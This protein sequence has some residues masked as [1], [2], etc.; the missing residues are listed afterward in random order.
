M[1]HWIAATVLVLSIAFLFYVL[2]GYPLLL[3]WLSRRRTQPVAR[4]PFYPR[5]S[6][7]IAVH[8]GEA[9]LRQKL[10]SVLAL[11][12]PRERMEI[13]VLSDAS[14]DATDAI[15][16]KAAA[17]EGIRHL[18][19]PRGGKAAALNAGMAAASGEVFVFTDVRQ[20]MDP[21]SVKLLTRCLADPKVGVVSGALVI[22]DPD[23]HEE[24]DTGL[25]W[26]Y[27]FWIR[28]H[29]SAL[30]SIFGATGACYAVRRELAVPIPPG[31][32]LDDM[33]LPLAAFFRGY[34]LIVEPA[35][36]VYDYPTA[37]KAEFQRKVRTL[38]GNYQII[39]Q[40]PRLLGW[41][42]RLWWHFVSYK[43][44]R[45]LL[46][47]V[48]LFILLSSFLLAHPWNYIL[49]G[50]Q[51]A[52]YGLG[53]MDPWVDQNSRLKR[54]SSIICTFLVLMGAGAYALRIFFTPS[55]KLWA[56]STVT[57]RS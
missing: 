32:L 19:L 41:S 11:D 7:L 14:T 33:Y 27:E 34:R 51:T 45:L 17:A 26:K 43:F 5:I 21:D 36:R 29:L 53:A 42:N 37:R 40:Y 56:Q 10:D 35:A 49:V 4:A 38:A 52:F 39:R 9:F 18:E 50:L 16:R 48:L 57:R 54:L 22:R 13:F 31:T 24:A 23:N 44:G 12:Y 1:I 25:Y 46:P 30:D 8:N 55:E 28:D 6:I 47:L 20:Q 3:G 2:F 15:A